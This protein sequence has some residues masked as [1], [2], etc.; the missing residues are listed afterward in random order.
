MKRNVLVI[1]THPSENPIF[2]NGLVDYLGGV[3][4]TPQ[5]IGGYD[6]QDVLSKKAD[7]VLLTGVPLDVNYSLSDD[8]TQQVIEQSFG[9]LRHC[10]QPVLGICYGHQILG[11]I[12]GGKVA[13]LDKPIIESQCR[14]EISRR[15]EQEIFGRIREMKVF[16]EHRDYVSKV[17]E[18]FGV[19]AEKGHVPYII[20]N[21]KRR[22][23]GCN[24]CL[25]CLEMKE[26]RS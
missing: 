14:L 15:V 23:M 1:N 16:I 22:I 20:C 24:L 17:P 3:G 13:T 6:S 18:E 25:R 10:E 26:E 12:F 8:E 4:I 11:H 2:L 7:R 19:I 9:W 5:V 21:P